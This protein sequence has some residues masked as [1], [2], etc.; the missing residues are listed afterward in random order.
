LTISYSY[1]HHLCV[2]VGGRREGGESEG[3]WGG[4]AGGGSGSGGAGRPRGGGGEGGGGKP[5]LIPMQI[6]P[7]TAS[8]LRTDTALSM[9][10][11]DRAEATFAEAGALPAQTWS[12]PR[13]GSHSHR[14]QHA[15]TASQDRDSRSGKGQRDPVMS[16]SSATLTTLGALP[17][18]EGRCGGE[19]TAVSARGQRTGRGPEDYDAGPA[20]MPALSGRRRRDSSRVATLSRPVLLSGSDDTAPQRGGAAGGGGGEGWRS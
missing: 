4:D 2:C 14:P 9:P 17:E 18:M 6:M 7:Q 5:A 8:S 15:E 19:A 12:R 16:R 11:S 13:H 1:I 10:L 3:G 20:T